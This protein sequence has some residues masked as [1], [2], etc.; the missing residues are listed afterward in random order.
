VAV[1]LR[2]YQYYDSTISI[3]STCLQR[4]DG[5]IVFQDGCVWMLKRCP[6]HGAERVLMADDI[7]YYKL[8]RETFIKTPE[9][10]IAPNTPAHYGCPY[11]CG[12]CPDHEQH[13]CTLLIEV[14]DNCNLRC[15]TCYAGSGPERQT[16]RSLEQIERMLDRAVANEGEPSIIQI[17]GGEPTVHPQFFEILELVKKRPIGHLL[18]NT[19]GVR[20]ANEPGFAEH[21]AQFTPGLEVYLQFDSFRPEVLKAL[22]STDLRST[23][24]RAVDRLNEFGIHT[25]LVSTIRRGLNDDEMGEIIDYGTQQACVRG[26]TFQPVQVAGRLEGYEA[27]YNIERDRLTLTEIRRRILEQCPVFAPEDLIPVPCHPDHLAM[28]YA[29]KLESGLVPLTGLIDQDFL[30]EAARST[31]SYE[32]DPAVREHFLNLFS[33]HHSVTSQTDAM[34][35]FLDTLERSPPQSL[36]YENIFRVLIVEFIDAQGFDLRSI[37]KTCVHIVHPDGKRVIPFDTYN[38]L[39]RDGLEENV[40]APLRKREFAPLTGPISIARYKD[41]ESQ[42]T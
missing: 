16:H 35:G 3:C 27:G 41:T 17:S 11:D 37:R 2:P 33:T 10:V 1:K 22:R 32:K 8:A 4:V 29:L 12:I 36:G 24:K 40:L 7:G 38:L 28:A 25:T 20:I 21:L 15:P 6:E 34:R 9:Q 42:S 30:I 23:H 39:Y 31:I 19:N 13:G 14:T 26:V 5:K 18:V